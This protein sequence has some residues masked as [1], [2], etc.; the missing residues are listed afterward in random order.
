MN[1]IIVIIAGILVSLIITFTKRI[2]GDET[3]F[4]KE[5]ERQ[6]RILKDATL[7]SW[8]FIILY[9]F[10]RLMNIIPYFNELVNPSKIQSNV[11]LGNGGDIFLICLVGYVIGAS[12][13]YFRHS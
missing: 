11:F 8:Q 5:D 12:V 13:S 6:K 7:T 1:I 3:G 9:A 2:S 4:S 10:F